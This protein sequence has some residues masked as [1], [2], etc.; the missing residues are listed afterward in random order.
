MA[1]IFNCKYFFIFSCA[2]AALAAAPDYVAEGNR[3]WSHI[4]VLAD[5]KMEGRNTGSQ[6]HRKAAEFVAGE[7]ER[8]G[9]KAAGTSG[10]LQP[11]KFNVTQIAEE[12]SSLAIARKG[13]A[14]PL[15]LGD[16]ATI[17]VRSGLAE[18]VDAPAVFVGYGLVIPEH[19]LDDFAGLDLK[20]KIVVYLA[21]GPAAVPS[22]LRAHYSSRGERWKAIQKAGAVGI[23]EIPNPKSMDIPWARATL[24]RMNTTM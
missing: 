2:A 12:S 8:D 14:T 19:H 7:F 23:A 22:A 10:Y 11:V 20:G 24:A 3:W 17:S 21:G 1:R 15:K 13:K 9:L 16:D 4:Q 5:D 18:H 6:G